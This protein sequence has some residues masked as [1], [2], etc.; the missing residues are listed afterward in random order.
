M[1]RF[2]ALTLFSALGLLSICSQSSAQS[3]PSATLVH[4]DIAKIV[5]DASVTA[6][7]PNQTAINL[8]NV[9]RLKKVNITGT[10][11]QGARALVKASIIVTYDG[12]TYGMCLVSA[13]G[14][15]YRIGTLHNPRKPCASGD[16]ARPKLNLLYRRY[17][18]GWR[19]E[20]VESDGF[21]HGGG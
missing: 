21:E 3:K 12:G 8:Q 4:D 1:N 5:K 15:G 19:L 2:L 20:N 9:M 16:E 7:S 13:K 6:S 14:F 11:V 18:T 17:D 10:S